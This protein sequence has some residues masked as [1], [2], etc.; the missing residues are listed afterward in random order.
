MLRMAVEK[1]LEKDPCDRYQ[2]MREIAVDLKRFTRATMA[3]ASAEKKA[4]R[5]WLPWVIAAAM[6]VGTAVWEMVRPAAR[7]PNPVRG[8]FLQGR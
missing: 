6:L 5:A 7:S 1:T 2:S 3:E 4:R 8:E